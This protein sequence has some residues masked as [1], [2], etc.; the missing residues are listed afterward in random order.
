MYICIYLETNILNVDIVKVAEKDSLFTPGF[1]TNYM[2]SRAV[3]SSHSFL[4]KVPHSLVCVYKVAN[5]HQKLYL[6]RTFLGNNF[7]GNK[8]THSSSESL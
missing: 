8:I 6:D 4:G 5:Q 7:Y 3:F 2:M 1:A